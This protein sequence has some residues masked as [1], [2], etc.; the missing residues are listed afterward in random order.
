MK[1]AP[2]HILLSVFAAAFHASAQI[3]MPPN[4]VYADPSTGVANGTVIHST[5]YGG[6]EGWRMF[7]G[8][9]G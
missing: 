3:P 5:S 4:A 7:D 1:K 9:F 6:Q 2:A 8:L